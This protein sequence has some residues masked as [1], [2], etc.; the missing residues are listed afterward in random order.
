MLYN[1]SWSYIYTFNYKKLE[2]RIYTLYPFYNYYIFPF[3][4]LVY[5]C[6]FCDYKNT[7]PL[8]VLEHSVALHTHQGNFSLRKKY[9]DE[10]SRFPV[11]KSVPIKISELKDQLNKQLKQSNVIIDLDSRKIR[12]KRKETSF[13]TYHFVSVPDPYLPYY[14]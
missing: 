6:Y 8:S 4:R 2:I 12:V 11:L 14:C 1:V 10:K 5:T 3:Q 7:A 9:F 13:K